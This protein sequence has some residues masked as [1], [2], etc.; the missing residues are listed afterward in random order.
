MKKGVIS[1]KDKYKRVLI[2]VENLPVPY[3]RRVWQ[4][5]TTLKKNGYCISV[6]CPKSK[7]FTKWHETLEGIFIYRHPLPPEGNS[8]VGYA[9]EYTMALFW[10]ML[11]AWHVF[12]RRG[13][14]VIHA[15]NPP[16]NIF[17]IALPFKLLGKKFVF[18]H[19]D[20]NPELFK[21]KFGHEGLL[22]K[23]LLL[24][25]RLTFRFADV[26]IA[27]NESYRNIAIKRGKMKPN[28]VFVVRSGPDLNK[29]K[30]IEPT[31][32]LKAGKKFLAGY[33]GIMAQQ[34]SIDGL[35]RI[36][37]YIIHKRQRCDIHF[38]LIGDGPEL[39]AMK[40][41]AESLKISNFITFT[42]FL[43]G[44][45]L[46]KAMSSIDIGLSPDEE[47]EYN[48]KCTMNKIMEYMA[49]GK[50]L[51]QYDLKE[52]RYSAEKASVYAESGNEVDFANKILM[53]IDNE[54]LRNEMGK[55]GRYRIEKLLN[56]QCEEPKLL[57][58]Y[59]CVF[60]V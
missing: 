20:I 10:Q 38:L 7:G 37:E 40:E 31:Q 2:I 46:H 47:N 57:Q 32:S 44:S 1:S 13:F 12:F 43:S 48:D 15:C 19:H 30:M 59:E 39:E 27:T 6:I 24:W 16:D 45:E 41:Y 17:L 52:G 35:L 29:L 22:Y 11:L 5:A 21:A 36:I 60:S 51:V 4:E 49:F 33:I 53:L 34:D 9:L 56:W 14:D 25:E 18:D 26:S 23:I 50:P 28:R 55:I 42:G 3:D 8:T 54:E 58:A